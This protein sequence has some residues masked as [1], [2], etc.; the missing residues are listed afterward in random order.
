[1]LLN[2]NPGKYRILALLTFVKV[3]GGAEVVTNGAM[4]R[5]EPAEM[6]IPLEEE[7]EVTYLFV[8]FQLVTILP[9]NI[10]NGTHE[11]EMK[12]MHTEM[13]PM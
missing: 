4:M 13:E 9:Q 2:L 12:T 3:G 5:E 11:I 1:M 7:E 6:E 8:W 10:T